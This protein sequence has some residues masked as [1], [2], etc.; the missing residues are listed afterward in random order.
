MS[1]EQHCAKCNKTACVA[2]CFG[3]QKSF[4]MT[5]FVKH[6]FYLAQ[7]M[8]RLHE[9]CE[10]LRKNIDLNNF[11][12]PFLSMIDD[13]E[14][15]S[16]KRI[17]EIAEQARNDLHEK[18]E[19]LIKDVE[20]SISKIV[21]EFDSHAE[22]D[23]YTEIE[24][25]KWAKQI[26]DLRNLIEEP[27][28]ISIIQD[29]KPASRIRGIKV[30]EQVPQIEQSQD[31]QQPPYAHF[32]Y[33]TDS[34]NSEHSSESVPEYFVPI[35]GPCTLSKDK[36]LVTQ[37]SYRAG[38][39]QI[40]GSTCYSQGRHSISFVIEKKSEKNIFVGIHSAANGISS[41]FDHSI[42]GWWNLDYIIVN[43]EHEC[44]E[45]TES[46]QTGDKITLVI[47]CDNQQVQLEHHRTKALTCLTVDLS[48]CP[49]PWQIL[50]RLLT[51]GDSIRI[52][53]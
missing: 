42:Y 50:I 27:T 25:E 45:S 20:F 33:E 28:T 3:C 14:Q 52:V 4:C 22:T 49:F 31:S 18:S 30:I 35:Y 36:F 29:K 5:H 26:A 9:K 1:E 37:S 19:N 15:R 17:Q 48:K 8:D 34:F 38:L 41:S 43:G 11:E 23:N 44:G 6:R 7:R 53:P 12:Q 32:I 16:I 47:D 51:A 13:W 39:S 10:L 40:S 46:I 21:S 24:L 2:N